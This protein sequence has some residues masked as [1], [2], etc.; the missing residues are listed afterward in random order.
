[1]GILAIAILKFKIVIKYD[2]IPYLVFMLFIVY[3]VFLAISERFLRGLVV[4]L[5]SL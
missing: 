2:R 5:F 4:Q 1:M 3:S